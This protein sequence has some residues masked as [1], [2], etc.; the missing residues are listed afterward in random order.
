MSEQLKKEP[1]VSQPA[2]S[3]GPKKSA[4]KKPLFRGKSAPKKKAEDPKKAETPKKK[5]QQSPNPGGEKAPAGAEKAA[6]TA[7]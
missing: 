7:C 4:P 3:E 5:P 6:E 1:G 2:G